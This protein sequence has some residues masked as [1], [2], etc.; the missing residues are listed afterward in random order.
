MQSE[1]IAYD[2]QKKIG[3]LNIAFESNINA[4]FEIFYQDSLLFFISKYNCETA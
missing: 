1:Y 4:D 2:N 3:N